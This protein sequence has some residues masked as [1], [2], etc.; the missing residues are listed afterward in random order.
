MHHWNYRVVHEYYTAQDEHGY[1]IREVY[2]EDMEEK[3]IN[4]YSDLIDPYGS[5]IDELRNDLSYMSSALAKPI[6][7]LDE[8]KLLFKHEQE[9]K[10]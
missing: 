5:S 7:E 9:E 10:A 1:T 4:C 8:L 2:Y 3:V 6:L